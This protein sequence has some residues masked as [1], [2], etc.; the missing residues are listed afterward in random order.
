MVPA[1][2]PSVLISGDIIRGKRVTGNHSIRDD[3]TNAGAE[4]VDL[5]VVVDGNILTAQGPNDLPLFMKEVLSFF[6][7]MKPRLKEYFPDGWVIDAHYDSIL[8]SDL[9]AGR[10]VVLFF[11]DS[12]FSP[13]AAQFL[14]AYHDMK[15]RMTGVGGL[16]LGISSD[17]FFSQKDAINHYQ[18]S[19]PLLSD[20]S[21]NLIKAFGVLG[22]KWL[23]E[24]SV[25]LIDKNGILRYGE[26]CPQG[27]FGSLP[28]FKRQLEN[29]IQ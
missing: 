20:V 2:A 21:G 29:I 22:K 5:P 23:A 19:Y 12:V 1:S 8:L 24:W 11:F 18:L 10:P 15:E 6:W 28:G 27:D 9:I 25:F 13:T 26:N 14:P 17:S 7:Q 16:F 3:I 4:F